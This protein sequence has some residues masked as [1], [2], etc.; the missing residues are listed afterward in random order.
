M[1][2]LK[3]EV[4]ERIAH[5]MLDRGTSNALND[6]MVIEL[7]KVLIEIENDESIG[8]L[9]LYGKQGFF[10]S[11]LD[12]ITLYDFDE[13]QMKDFWFEFLDLIKTFVA[14]RKPAIAAIGG[15]SPAGGC[16]LA[17]CC[18]YRIMTEGEYIIGLNEV[19]V[20]IIVPDSIF[21]LYS[22]WLGRARAYRFLLEGT[23]LHPQRAL[24]V[25]LIDEMVLPNQL[26]TQADKQMKKYINLNWKTWQLSKLNMRKE[27]IAHFSQDPAEA[28]DMVLK[29]WWEPSTR[30]VVKTIIDNL[31]SKQ[32]SKNE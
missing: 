32:P 5:L 17:L 12:L 4:K 6:K 22:F 16:V 3:L 13:K 28:I 27:L 7:K 11:G 10:S 19:P 20:G 15:H 29:Q 18:D 30:S 8:G 23:L 9:I 26:H 21:D 2:Y 14:F 31:K 24:K 25:G 1:D